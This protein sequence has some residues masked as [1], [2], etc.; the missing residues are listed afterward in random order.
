MLNEL[1]WVDDE[2][3]TECTI[4]LPRNKAKRRCAGP[5]LNYTAY[6]LRLFAYSEPA[7]NNSKMHF[8]GGTWM[9]VTT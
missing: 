6:R 8:F 7:A 1:S 3:G 2:P 5:S 4:F 9:P